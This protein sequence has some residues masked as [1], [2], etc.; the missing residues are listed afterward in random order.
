MLTSQALGGAPYAF[1]ALPVVPVQPVHYLMLLALGLIASAL[2]IG[3]MQVTAWVE[4]GFDASRMPYWARPA[5]GGLIVGALALI[6]P[7]V[8]AAGHGAMR[9]DIPLD[10][11][12]KALALMI[13]LKLIA[14][15]VSLGSGF[16]GGLFFASLFVGSLVGKLSGG[17]YRTLAAGLRAGP[18]RLRAR[19]HGRRSPW[20]S[21]AGR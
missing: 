9:L 17:V 6:T 5:V 10:L 19:R 20:R 21:W 4:R 3:V 2:G 12:M 14:A 8:L 1:H 18:H 11:P 7:Q 15:L 13:A 16:R